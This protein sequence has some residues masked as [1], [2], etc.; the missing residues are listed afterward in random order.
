MNTTTTATT[1]EGLTPWSLEATGEPEIQRVRAHIGG[2]HCSLCTGT[3]ERALGQKPGVR[4]VAVSLTHEQALVEYD[5]RENSAET[6]MGTLQAIGYTLSDPRKIEPYAKQERELAGERNR[7]LVALATSL[8]AVGLIVDPT[9]PWTL[10]LSALVYVSLVIFGYAVLR[11]QGTRVA[12]GGSALLALGGL[13]LFGLRA[14]SMLAGQEA[15]LVAVLAVAMVFGIARQML[16]MA[17]QALRRGILNQHVLVE[18]GASAGVVGGG[19]GLVLRPDG[20]P[21]AAFFA[22]SVMVLTYHL[23]SEWLSLIVKT[24][25]SQSVRRLLDLQPETAHV[26]DEGGE[27]DLPVEQ[28][29]TGMWVRIRPGERIPVDGEV[30]DGDSAVDQSLVTGEPLPIEK[31][32]G[33]SV[34]GGAINGNGTL[35]V[36]VTATGESS[37][38]QQVVRSLEDARALK[39]G[40]LHLVDRVLRVYTPTVLIVSALAFVFWMSAPLLWD[41]ASDL[42]R[43][44][45]AALTVLVMGYPCAVGI[46]APLSIVRGAGEAADQG[47]LMRTGESFQA[48]RRVTTVVF[49]KTG[50]L[51]EGR[52]AVREVISVEGDDDTLLSL[53]AA[54]ESASEHPLGRAVVEAALSRDL[55]I[56]DVAEF[57]AHAGRGV[58]AR[59]DDEP[60]RVGSPAFLAGQGMDLAPVSDGIARAEHQGQTVIVLAR[61]D[62]LLGAIALGDGLRADA[63]E[64][65]QQ[66]RGL[67]IRTALMTGDNERSAQHIAGLVGIDT[68]Y[69]GVLPEQKADVLREMQQEGRVAMVGDGINDAPA[70][71]QADVGI[72]MGSGTDIAIDAA[73]IIILNAQ[74][75]SVVTAWRI[76]RWGY[77][78]MLQNVSLAF[79]FNGIGIPLASTGLIYPV[80]AM[81][82]MAASVTTIFINSLWQRPSLLFDAVASVRSH[83]P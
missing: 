3:I 64:T 7:F 25:S 55:A 35:V 73:D 14:G 67:G 22:V 69:A 12:L 36:R 65:A 76:S 40:L 51:T 29:Q 32:A 77:R 44:V 2:L 30:I 57:Q 24:R 50:T 4:R 28:V 42:E 58:T 33:D 6:L 5:T 70:L 71:M 9:S 68:V 20:Y 23:F 59:V 52:P 47:V 17:Y 53:A 63:A 13:V 21:T 39:P 48:L 82:A 31:A 49:D 56:P 74:V 11:G 27:R 54:V 1:A 26:L 34:V 19:I 18:I 60:V 46:S 61:G 37:F 8:A 38:L 75:S 83:T 16:V 66:L 43:A 80:W 15:I 78:K 79:L 72:A 45:F 10:G 81:V 62:R 41:A